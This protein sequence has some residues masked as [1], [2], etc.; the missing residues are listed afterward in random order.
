[1]NRVAKTLMGVL[2]FLLLAGVVIL[3]GGIAY[4]VREQDVARAMYER[5]VELS[6]RAGYQ[7]GMDAVIEVSPDVEA[8]TVIFSRYPKADARRFAETVVRAS[9]EYRVPMVILAGMVMQES[10]CD[11]KAYSSAGARGL[12]QVT[13]KW[14]GPMLKKMG[15]AQTEQDLHVPEI[16]IE[17]GAAVLRYLLDKYEGDLEKAMKHYSGGATSYLRK[18][19][20]RVLG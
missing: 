15:I 5:D 1:M 12:T 3:G 19:V 2:V 17:A 18:V 14:W 10:S 20:R 16:G 9:A 4:M 8:L 7:H 11:T 13:W 6:Y